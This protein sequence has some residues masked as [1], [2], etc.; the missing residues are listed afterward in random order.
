M[1][2]RIYTHQEPEHNVY[3]KSNAT[4][5][6]NI[7]NSQGDNTKFRITEDITI[8]SLQEITVN[9]C[10]IEC[11]P[12]KYLICSNN[13]LGVLQMSG[14]DFRI[15]SLNIKTQGD[16]TSA[17]ILN[18]K[19]IANNVSVIH[20]GVGKTLTNAVRVETGKIV[21]VIGNTEIVNG[22]ITNKVSDADGNS[23]F[24]IDGVFYAN[25]IV[26]ND[27]NATDINA[28]TV[29]ATNHTGANI[30][31]GNISA[32]NVMATNHTGVNFTG[33]QA[34]VYNITGINIDANTVK[35]AVYE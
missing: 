28:T 20:D 5:L 26:G 9:G 11:D 31:G 12:G 7:V 2:E 16:I 29:M 23:S 17:L 13:I 10:T 8:S 19:G 33:S 25:V 3:L 18:G 22:A 30:V 15:T 35:G 6:A 34:T 1:E 24:T 14:E 21:S 32:T 4:D 27:V